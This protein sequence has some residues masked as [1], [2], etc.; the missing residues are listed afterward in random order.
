MLIVKGRCTRDVLPHTF[1]MGMF[2]GRVWWYVL[3]F[4]KHKI[5]WHQAYVA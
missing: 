1:N 2:N 5:T 4:V 3:T